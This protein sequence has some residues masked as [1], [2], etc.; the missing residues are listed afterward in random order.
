MVKMNPRGSAAYRT[1]SIPNIFVGFQGR[2]CSVGQARFGVKNLRRRSW[3]HLETGPA[4][5]V[6]AMGGPPY[7]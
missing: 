5:R 2:L 1:Q 4:Q 7:A 6:F 3:A